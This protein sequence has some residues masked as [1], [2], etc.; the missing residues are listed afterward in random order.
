MRSLSLTLTCFLAV[1][2]S[3][4]AT[5]QTPSRTWSPLLLTEGDHV[6]IDR[7]TIETVGSVRRVWLRWQYGTLRDQAQFRLERHEV[8]CRLRRDRILAARRFERDQSGMDRTLDS[9]PSPSE[10]AW[11]SP[12]TG[13]IARQVVNAVCEP[14]R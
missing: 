2:S 12:S 6:D 8:D 10:M 11:S 4:P 1:G 3:V 9:L 13:S 5:G 7:G 14:E